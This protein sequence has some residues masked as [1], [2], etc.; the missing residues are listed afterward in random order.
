MKSVLKKIREISRGTFTVNFCLRTNLR[1][2]FGTEGEIKHFTMLRPSVDTVKIISKI[3][4]LVLNTTDKQQH[5]HISSKCLLSVR[6]LFR[7]KVLVCSALKYCI[8]IYTCGKL[9]KQEQNERLA[10]AFG[11]SCT[12]AKPFK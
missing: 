7:K 10:V 11:T 6:C 4:N 3:L 8:Y 1:R 5:E 12:K 9:P 2:C